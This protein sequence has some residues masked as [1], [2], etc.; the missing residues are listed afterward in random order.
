[1]SNELW[2]V[3]AQGPDDLYAAFSREDAEK[4]A[5]ELN[6]LPMPEGISV[7]AVVIP[8]PWPEAEHWK[9]LAEQEREHGDAARAAQARVA[10]LLHDEPLRCDYCQREVDD[11]WHGSGLLDG[12][13]CRHIHACDNCRSSLLVAQTGHAPK[14]WHDVQAERRR[15]IEAEDWTL[16]HDDQHAPGE[17]ARAAA[18]YLLY[19][20]P[21]VPFDLTLASRLWPRLSGFNPKGVRRDLVRACAMA[22]AE[23]E[24]LDRSAV[25]A[26]G[27]E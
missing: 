4:H 26:Q 27:G 11:P 22:L 21:R 25:P 8:S 5:A 6:R 3:H 1:M 18:A 10:E 17:L 15:Q 19:A 13:E 16:E 24:R 14:A 9:Y 7:G 12:D 20:F 2:A 23:L